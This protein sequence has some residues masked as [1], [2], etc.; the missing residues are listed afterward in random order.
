MPVHHYVI[1]AI[2]I[3]LFIIVLY[4]MNR[5]ISHTRTIDAL[6]RTVVECTQQIQYMKNAQQD[7]GYNVYLNN[8]S[9]PTT[10]IVP[11]TQS[12]QT[13]QENTEQPNDQQDQKENDP[14]LT[15]SILI[16]GVII[17]TT[18]ITSTTPKLD[19]HAVF[20]SDVH[21]G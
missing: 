12:T 6:E 17:P 21:G 7:I 11:N 8:N 9:T 10:P 19:I 14:P 20:G 16:E 5:M 4:I 3:L 18:N 15:E 2:L 1:I 13:V